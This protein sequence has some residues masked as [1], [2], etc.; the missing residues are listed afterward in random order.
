M[1]KI[2]SYH[3]QNTHER[4][5]LRPVAAKK[6]FLMAVLR[7]ANKRNLQTEGLVANRKPQYLSTQ[8]VEFICLW[9]SHIESLVSD[10][11]RMW[12]YCWVNQFRIYII[13]NANQEYLVPNNI[14]FVYLLDARISY[15]FPSESNKIC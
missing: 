12:L 5:Q 10:G 11:I 2:G 9:Y 13:N 7:L 3:T 1:K 8:L 6:F 4:A 15:I 14:F